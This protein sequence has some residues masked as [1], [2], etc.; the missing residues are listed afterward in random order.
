VAIHAEKLL[1]AG[2]LYADLP[3][4]VIEVE[5]L[6]KE[7][8]ALKAK[9]IETSAQTAAETALMKYADDEACGI[10]LRHRKA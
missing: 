8:D 3:S 2:T 9:K 1:P 5:S 10:V 6:R 4:V 7:I